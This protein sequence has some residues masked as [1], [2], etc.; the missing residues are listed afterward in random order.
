MIEHGGLQGWSSYLRWS[1]VY[2]YIYIWV[3]KFS[4]N[5]TE[6]NHSLPVK[7]DGLSS[8]MS[9]LEVKIELSHHNRDSDGS[10]TLDKALVFIL[11]ESDDGQTE[12]KKSKKKKNTISTKNFGAFLSISALKSAENLLLVWRCRWHAWIGKKQLFFM[13]SLCSF[14]AETCDKTI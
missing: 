2:I 13:Y 5:S 11:D 8:M 6:P 4:R 7:N 10:L 14:F 12:G 3:C 1:I 9:S